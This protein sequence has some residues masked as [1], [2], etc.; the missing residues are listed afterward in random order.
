MD[1]KTTILPYMLEKTSAKL[2]AQIVDENGVGIPVTSLATLILD[3]YS[4]SDPAKPIINNR[5]A[6]DVLGVNNVS[7]DTSGN[8]IWD[9]QPADNAILD[10][11]LANES[12][13]A[14]F[15]WTYNGG[16]KAGKYIIDMTVVNLAKVI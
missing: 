6:Q 12:H 9:I 7:I 5:T 2:T 15:A 11:T 10:S 1:Y 8:L 3:L 4:M 13:R 16:A 14:V